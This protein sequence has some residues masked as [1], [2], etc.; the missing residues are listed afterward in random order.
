MKEYDKK[1]WGYESMTF[2]HDTKEDKLRNLISRLEEPGK[3]MSDVYN[4]VSSDNTVRELLGDSLVPIQKLLIE[5]QK[6]L[7]LALIKTNEQLSV[8]RYDRFRELV[9]DM[10]KI[11]DNEEDSN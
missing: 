6:N 9:E 8:L 3:D 4:D 11:L 7:T 5:T 10:D 2:L 1:A